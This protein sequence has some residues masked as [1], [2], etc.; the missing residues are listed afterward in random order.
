[1]YPINFIDK[2]Y[3]AG[4]GINTTDSSIGSLVAG[5]LNYLGF[6]VGVAAVVGIVYGGVLIIISAGNPDKMQ[7]G[8]RA[9]MWSIIGLLIII[10]AFTIIGSLDTIING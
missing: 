5:A 6:F 9:L 7:L 1:M 8:K 2:V 10:M 3:A 4:V